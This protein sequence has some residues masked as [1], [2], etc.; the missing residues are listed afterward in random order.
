MA[1]PSNSG[2]ISRYPE[3]HRACRAAQ[4]VWR[5]WTYDLIT[6]LLHRSTLLSLEK[7]KV[8]AM[9]APPA[10]RVCVS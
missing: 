1:V 6:R 2:S 10:R 9:T 7:G 8:F 5:Q 4:M 3:A